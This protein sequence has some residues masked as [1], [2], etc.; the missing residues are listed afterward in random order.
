ME[1]V[2]DNPY[3]IGTHWFQYIDSPMTGRAYDGEND[4][5][6]VVTITD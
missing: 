3:F 1:S 2:I 6:G 4:N 5:V